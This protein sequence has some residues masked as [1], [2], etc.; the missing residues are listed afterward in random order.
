MCRRVN[1]GTLSTVTSLIISKEFFC[2][3]SFYVANA[4]QAKNEY[5]SRK[6]KEEAA[7]QRGE[8]TWMLPSVESKLHKETKKKRKKEKKKKKHKKTK[9]RKK[10]DSSSST[11]SVDRAVKQLY[12]GE[13]FHYL[14][15]SNCTFSFMFVKIDYSI[16]HFKYS[17]III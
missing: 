8:H 9:K 17:F 5:E 2:L 12:N 3:I 7:R 13:N 4:F 11:V 10:D 15:A 16:K 6:L 1:T 14:F